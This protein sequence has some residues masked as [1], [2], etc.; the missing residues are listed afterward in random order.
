MS[1]EVGPQ[2]PHLDYL[3]RLEGVHATQSEVLFTLLG[4]GRGAF[5]QRGWVTPGDYLTHV[6][7]PFFG[8]E[9]EVEVEIDEDAGVYR[10]RSL[11]VRG[12]I[13]VE[14]LAEIALYAWQ[15]EVWLDDL[16]DLIGIEPRRRSVRRVRVPD[17]LWHLGEVRIA[18]THDFAPV[19]VGRRLEQ[20]PESEVRAVLA[21]ARW[22]RGGVFLR[23]GATAANLPG[24][25]VARGLSDFILQDED[26]QDAFDADGLD[27]VLR[28]FVS[29]SGVPEPK[30]FIQANR[31]KLPH[32]S[33]SLELSDERARIVQLAWGTD[34][35][36]PPTVSWA[37]INLQ[38][39]TGYQSFD[40]AFDKG[41]PC[42]RDQVFDRVG[43]G[44]YRLRRDP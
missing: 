12:R 44:K 37:E 22:P 5:I 38:A 9:Q 20:A 15:V 21:D 35:Y 1:S 10:Y 4:R 33:E 43:Y 14:P 25:H 16:A 42:P 36:A 3:A 17:H 24:D 27:R 8:S 40:D 19:F 7:V 2:S 13:I 28:G 29:P 31:L 39:R 18:G 41:C 23:H 6:M 30:Q 26:G 34:G 32:F 11:Q